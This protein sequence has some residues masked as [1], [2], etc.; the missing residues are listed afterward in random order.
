MVEVNEEEDEVEIFVV[1]VVGETR[2]EGREV[3]K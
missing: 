3:G 2:K 1:V